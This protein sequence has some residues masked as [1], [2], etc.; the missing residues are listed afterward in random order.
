MGARVL[1]N[2]TWYYGDLCAGV[3]LVDENGIGR[4]GATTTKAVGCNGLAL[5]FSSRLFPT[6]NTHD[7]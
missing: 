6:L 5:I 4:I 1:I 7:G 3:V 2:G